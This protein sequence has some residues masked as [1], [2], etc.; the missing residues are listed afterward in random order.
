MV[1]KNLQRRFI[2]IDL[3]EEYV[4][5]AQDRVGISVDKPDHLREDESQIGIETFAAG[6]GE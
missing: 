1:A 6:G 3:N 5:M 4:A 2:G